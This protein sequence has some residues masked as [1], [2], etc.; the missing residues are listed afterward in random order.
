MIVVLPE[1]EFDVVVG[2]GVTV[3]CVALTGDVVAE[4]WLPDPFVT[5][6]VTLLAV[7]LVAPAPAP[8]DVA[9]AVA[10]AKVPV[11]PSALE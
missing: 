1:R 3:C 5:A 6:L 4:V 9:V 2:V 10:G 11:E 8:P 7:L